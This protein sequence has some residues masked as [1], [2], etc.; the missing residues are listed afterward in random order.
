M[1]QS[2]PTPEFEI[3]RSPADYEA[4]GKLPG[5]KAVEK[6]NVPYSAPR[7]PLPSMSENWRYAMRRYGSW[8]GYSLAALSAVGLLVWAAAPRPGKQTETRKT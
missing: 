3:P 1:R 8:Q 6:L 5:Y 2:R 4:V 7:D